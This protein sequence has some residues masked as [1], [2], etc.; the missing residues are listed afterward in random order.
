VT[1]KYPQ[2]SLALQSSVSKALNSGDISGELKNCA[3]AIEKI[4]NS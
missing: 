2:V 1:P 4:V 3:A